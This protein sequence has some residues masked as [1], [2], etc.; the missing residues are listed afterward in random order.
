M[1]QERNL[2]EELYL[3]SRH[4]VGCSVS[5]VNRKVQT[6]TIRYFSFIST[7]LIKYK[8][9]YQVLKNINVIRISYPLLL[10]V[11]EPVKYLRK[12]FEHY[13][14]KFNISHPL[15]TVPYL[16]LLME[17]WIC[18]TG[19]THKNVQ[20]AKVWKIKILKT[21]SI[22]AEGIPGNL[23]VNYRVYTHIVIFK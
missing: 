13:F 20:R 9:W 5:L 6:K 22:P 3:A 14:P 11:Y 7:W 16:H 8:W 19:G 12:I 2:K 23:L 17:T 1:A 21:T 4:D 18:T 15:S 10:V